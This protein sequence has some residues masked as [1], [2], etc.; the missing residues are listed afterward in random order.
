MTVVVLTEKQM[1]NSIRLRQ[2]LPTI[3]APTPTISEQTCF[4]ARA[5]RISGILGMIV[6]SNT[7]PDI[8]ASKRSL[9]ALDKVIESISVRN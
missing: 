3:W 6:R 9:A 4:S 8:L 2:T 7:S 5:N 1:R